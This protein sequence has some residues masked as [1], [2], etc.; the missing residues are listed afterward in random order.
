MFQISSC[1]VP[2]TKTDLENATLTWAKRK[3]QYMQP[4]SEPWQLFSL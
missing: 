4:N 2:P 1:L 3:T